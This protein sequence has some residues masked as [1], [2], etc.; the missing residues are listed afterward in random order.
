MPSLTKIER[1]ILAN[2]C[3]I[4]AILNESDAESYERYREALENGYEAGYRGLLDNMEDGLSA[5]QCTFVIDVLTMY[6]ALQRSQ[7]ALPAPSAIPP[8]KV[9]FLGFDG[10]NES[11]YRGYTD[12]VVTQEQRF[13][14]LNFGGMG[15]NSHMPMA[16]R[17]RSMLVKWRAYDASYELTEQQLGDILER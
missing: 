12:F 8:D 11:E 15:F 16:G 9:A 7:R 5:D 17:Y 2:Q 3:A 1:L 13:D 10:N 14:Y 4:L 6:D